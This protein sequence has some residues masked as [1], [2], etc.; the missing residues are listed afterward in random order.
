MK[1]SLFILI[2]SSFLLLSAA[3]QK[4][5]STNWEAECNRLNKFSTPFLFGWIVRNIE[6]SCVI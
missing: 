1:K 6:K 4:S 3:P 2:L 5:T